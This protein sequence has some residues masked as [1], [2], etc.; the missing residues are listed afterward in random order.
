MS[1][2]IPML[3]QEITM[4]GVQGYHS[5]YISLDDGIWLTLREGCTLE[6]ILDIAKL[7]FPEFKWSLINGP[8]ETAGYD[9]SHWLC[10]EYIK[11]EDQE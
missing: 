4:L 5:G 6:D 10:Y 2:I 9:W 11:P 7:N 1:R 8:L 3:S